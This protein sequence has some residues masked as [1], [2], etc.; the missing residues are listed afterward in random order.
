M[1]HQIIVGNTLIVV[2]SIV[3]AMTIGTFVLRIIVACCAIYMIK[4]GFTMVR[5]GMYR[6][7]YR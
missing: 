4:C 7:D 3:L 2:G 1:R 5:Y 6:N